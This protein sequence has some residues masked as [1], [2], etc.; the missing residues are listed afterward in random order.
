[1]AITLYASCAYRELL[2]ARR[3]DYNPKSKSAL[4]QLEQ[5]G[6][7]LRAVYQGLKDEVVY[8][9][10]EL[11]EGILALAAWERTGIYPAEWSPFVA[12]LWLHGHTTRTYSLTHM[13][14]V[15]ELIRRKGGVRTIRLHGVAWMMA[16]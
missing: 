2:R 7:A 11:I 15:Y 14:V 9:S 6:Q 8:L 1:M 13:R 10:D 12:P 3:P 4:E 16:W 5:K